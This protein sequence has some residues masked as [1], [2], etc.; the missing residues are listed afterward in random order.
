MIDDESAAEK[1]KQ[2]S[3]QGRKN[4]QEV[5]LTIVLYLHLFMN[6]GRWHFKQ[7]RDPGML[8]MVFH[9]VSS[10]VLGFT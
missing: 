7:C 1:L 4:C 10:H 3:T 6:I 2:R 8:S 9:R 5:S